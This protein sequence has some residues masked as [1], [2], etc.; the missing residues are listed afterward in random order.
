MSDISFIIVLN[1]TGKKEERLAWSEKLLTKTRRSGIK[2]ILFGKVIHPKTN[3]EI[4]E[5][6][7]KGNL[8]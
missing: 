1:Y 8:S 3:E 4:H 5:K 2:D 6:L 7:I